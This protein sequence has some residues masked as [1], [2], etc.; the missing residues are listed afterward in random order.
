MNLLWTFCLLLVVPTWAQKV[1]EHQVDLGQTITLNC[2]M[3][4]ENILWYLEIYSGLWATIVRIFDKAGH[5]PIYHVHTLD[6]KFE[7]QPGN[8]L[9]IKNVTADDYRRYSCRN[10]TNGISFNNIVRLVPAGQ[11]VLSANDSEPEQQQNSWRI[12]KSEEL[13]IGSLALNGALFFLLAGLTLYFCPKRSRKYQI[14]NPLSDPF[15]TTDNNCP[16]Y[17]EILLS[18][19]EVPRPATAPPPGCVYSKVQLP[20]SSNMVY[21]TPGEYLPGPAHLSKNSSGFSELRP[22]QKP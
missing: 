13:M 21:C 12:L 7:I 2:T 17:E 20:L 11:I 15:E 4:T 8:K 1:S 6:P 10:K 22:K 9:V 14:N 18:T 5:S 3:N 19:P 16:Q